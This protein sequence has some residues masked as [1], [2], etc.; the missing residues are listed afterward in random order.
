VTFAIQA[1]SAEVPSVAYRR[2]QGYAVGCLPI[3]AAPSPA[4]A[5]EGDVGHAL[6]SGIGLESD[7][8]KPDCLQ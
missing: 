1:E 6:G 3:L 2:D 8:W 7:V 5:Q 4:L